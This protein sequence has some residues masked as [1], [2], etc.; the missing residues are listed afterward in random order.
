M[1][2]RHLSRPGLAVRVGDD[3]ERLKRPAPPT[4]LIESVASGWYDRTAQAFVAAACK[5]S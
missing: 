3:L 2:W 1:V 5:A 4:I